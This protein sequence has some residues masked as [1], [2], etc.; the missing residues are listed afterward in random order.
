MLINEALSYGHRN[1]E[2]YKSYT[3]I[4]NKL[5]ISTPINSEIRVQL[6]KDIYPYLNKILKTELD[7]TLQNSLKSNC[8]KFLKHYLLLFLV[9]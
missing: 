8:Y 2:F 3:D 1:L 9:E 5:I 6:G 7:E 4:E